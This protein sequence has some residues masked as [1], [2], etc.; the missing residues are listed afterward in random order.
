M[1]S[2]LVLDFY[3]FSWVFF[4][5]IFWILWIS[6]YFSPFFFSFYFSNS[7]IQHFVLI[8]KGSESYIWG[9]YENK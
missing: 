7:K 3:A 4:F 9:I 1:A 8:V 6:G 2:R 5:S